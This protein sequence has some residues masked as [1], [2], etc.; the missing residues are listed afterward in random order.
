MQDNTLMLLDTGA[1]ISLI[2]LKCLTG[3][4]LINDNVKLKL[5]GIHE[6]I[7]ET[8]G[9]TVLTL[10]L[11]NLTK[12]H[13]F[14]VVPNDFK[15]RADAVMGR[16]L[17]V[18]M[19]ANIDYGQRCLI[20][21]LNKIPLLTSTI[22]VAP[23]TEQIIQIFVDRN[24][25]GL[26]E[27]QEIE[28]GVFIPNSVVT[29]DKNKA[30]V[31]IVNTTG[32][33][34]TTS[35]IACKLNDFETGDV[36]LT[37]ENVGNYLKLDDLNNIEE[38]HIRE[39]CVQ[40]RDVF[41]LPGDKLTC[42]NTVQH[43]IPL[44][45]NTPPIHVKPYRLP[46]A[47]KEEINKQITQML[48][49]GTIQHSTS[50]YNAPLVVVPKKLDNSGIRKWRIA[51]DFRRLNDV[52][53]GTSFP[54]P[55]IIGILDQ[56][57][58][59]KYYSTLDLASGFHQILMK[60]EDR[61][62]T[63]F[64]TANQHL[65]FCRMP[66]GLK[67]APATFQRLMNSVLDGLI[68]EICFVYLD[69]IVIFSSTLEEHK[70][71]LIQV[72][73][74]LR[75]HSL[76]LQP[77][78]CNFLKRRIKFLG[79]CITED[80]VKPD[81]EKIACINKYPRPNNPKEIKS[82]LGLIGYY[83]RFIPDFAKVAKPLN[84][85]LK[86]DIHFEWTQDQ[87]NAFEK[88]KEIIT[89]EPIL[90]YPD[91]GKEFILTT[92][93]SKIALGAV[94]S[95]GKVG[96]DKPIA[97]ASRTL[98]SAEQHYSTTE[99]EL[100]SILWATDHFRPYLYGRRFRIITDHRPLK[101]LLSVKTP[102]SRLMRWRLK[103]EEYDYEIEY[104][105]GRLNSNADALSRVQVNITN[106]ES[107]QETSESTP[108]RERE[109]DAVQEDNKAAPIVKLHRDARGNVR[110]WIQNKEEQKQLLREYHD[111]PTAGHQGHRRTIAV[112]KLKY[113]WPNL[114][115]DVI[116]YINTCKSCNER[117]TLPKDS[118]RAPMEITSTPSKVFEIVHMDIVGPLPITDR[119]NK[120]L[121]T[122]QDAFSKYPEAIPIPDQTARTVAEK[123]VT[124]IICKHGTPKKLITD[125]GS[126]FLSELF[127]E[128]CKLLHISKLNTSAYHPQTNGVVERSHRTL[129]NYLSHYVNKEQTDWD[130]WIPFALFAYRVTPH[131]VTGFSPFLMVNGREP[132]LPSEI[133]MNEDNNQTVEYSEE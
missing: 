103:L 111:L 14:H 83:R 1:D 36:C 89:T 46:E 127:I 8:I 48:A 45:V 76:L 21:G 133:V 109:S 95:Q 119:R 107:K 13:Y 52:T 126:N 130:V 10:E 18:D 41:F 24:G 55:N 110:H 85:L 91:F 121:L 98:N 2:K 108:E 70:S 57:G 77:D 9:R 100:L 64:S 16:D 82:F 80:G 79:H 44:Q 62:K 19:K 22:N 71:R 78:K 81:E 43:E 72:F 123:F 124:E 104:K 11:G 35:K 67:G 117:K 132:N 40:Y 20:I 6:N 28:P 92:D 129:M 34:I 53:I 96:Q 73:E 5:Q 93:A 115:K 102:G 60:P 56:L 39:L 87:Q 37:S 131:S 99:L 116:D 88:L 30:T 29:A 26:V 65:E 112:L 3:D 61:A 23:R 101:W 42:T 90:Q 122:F 105:A 128:I 54:L 74:R 84:N 106:A 47:Q 32:K 51:V 63:A 4:T 7:S 49:N 17:L 69:D 31:M 97:Y 113:Y 118:L 125:Q 59:S 75:Q 38:K 120:Y 15:I 27:E 114:K 25:T 50:P 94:L 33:E 68:G 12:E 86:K 66:F 58:N